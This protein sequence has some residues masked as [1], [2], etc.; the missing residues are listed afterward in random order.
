MLANFR[1]LG[2]LNA[3]SGTTRHGRLSRSAAPTTDDPQPE[4]PFALVVDLRCHSERGGADHPFAGG[5][6]VLRLT[7]LL[8]ETE[9]SWAQANTGRIDLP[10]WYVHALEAFGARLV[11]S[12][13]ACIAA[14]GPTLVHCAAGKDRTGL[15]VALLLG[16]AGVDSEAIVTDY[17]RTNAHT[18]EIRRRDG[19]PVSIEA[20]E[21]AIRAALRH[22]D[23][24]GGAAAW[25]VA[26]Y[27]TEDEVATWRRTLLSSAEEH[28]ASRR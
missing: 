6:S 19:G 9:L 7:P 16:L 18:H 21:R 4:P 8:D 14:G 24:A 1:D 10:V 22:W 26:H 15:L 2:G 17:M 3:G 12:A 27:G 5:G 11:Q 28:D 23:V 20:Q 25:F 13:R